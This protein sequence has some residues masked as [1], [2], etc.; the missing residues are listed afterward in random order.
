M[1]KKLRFHSAKTLFSALL[2]FSM[3]FSL[4]AVPLN[5][6]AIKA[7][8]APAITVWDG[9]TDTDWEGE[10]TANSPYLISSGAELYG[11]VIEYC[12][13]WNTAEPYFKLTSDIYLNDVSVQN[14]YLQSG[15]K[16]WFCAWE[17]NTDFCFK[18]HFEG[19]GHT[20]YGIY[21]N[22]TDQ[23]NIIHGLIPKLAGNATVN[24]VVI[25]DLYI[26]SPNG[27]AGA[28]AGAINGGNVA[29][30]R[31]VVGADVIINCKEAGGLVGNMHD[32]TA[33][34]KYCGAAAN[35]D[36]TSK[37]GAV[38]AGGWSTTNLT[39]TNSYCIGTPGTI[40]P[41]C[42][43][44][45]YTTHNWPGDATNSFDELKMI[46]ESA[47]TN[48][49]LLDWKVF[50]TT[51]GYPK[52]APVA[53]DNGTVG[54][55]WSGNEA[56]NYAGGDGT[57][58]SPYQI[59]T[60]A[61]LR[62]MVAEFGKNYFDNSLYYVLTADIYLNDTSAIDNWETTPPAN[63]WY[64]DSLSSD[65][66]RG[67]LDGA[68]HTVYGLYSNTDT[69]EYWYAAS[70]IQKFAPGASIKNLHIRN[71]YLAAPNTGASAIFG[72]CDTAGDPVTLSGC[73]VDASVIIKAK[74]AGGL[75][76]IVPTNL[77]VDNCY[78][79]CTGSTLS[80][81]DYVGAMYGDSW[82]GHTFNVSNCYFDGCVP[83]NYNRRP[84]AGCVKAQN[85]YIINSADDTTA[86]EE[87]T[88]DGFSMVSSYTDINLVT[89]DWYRIGGSKPLLKNRGVVLCDVDADDKDNLDADDLVALRKF[90]LGTDGY[91]NIIS[92]VTKDGNS[93]IL[94]LVRLKKLVSEH[95]K[96]K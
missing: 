71:S 77:N 84:G 64:S 85:S 93:D 62:K 65:A 67:H 54:E 89:P 87:L 7:N 69:S 21:Y 9:S 24:N 70:L 16:T 52:I 6:S 29:I 10:G 66:W 18:G 20:V 78:V 53:Y 51:I 42:D 33:F 63:N 81:T 17:Y 1:K 13:K 23:G 14:W 92:D 80:G 34:F 8:A 3:V 22:G 88:A 32:A 96:K 28:V 4:F 43:K 74:V 48:M 72:S 19:D 58:A 50:E 57:E 68:G 40:T 12:E 25:K 76:A 36:G 49:P 91:G 11:M 35:V 39:I 38:I 47:K 31:C 27:V 82:G 55:V 45:L 61:Q 44:S 73:S 46:G 95:Q 59:E 15:L 94:D 75:F 30:T 56:T 79:A 41:T 86:G 37:E 83:Y 60:G 2:A 26:N 90:L 5:G